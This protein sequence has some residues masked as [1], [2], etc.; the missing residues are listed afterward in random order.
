[1]VRL[2]RKH[3]AALC[4]MA[5]VGAL[6]M[7]L[8]FA[9]NWTPGIM[10][11]P[12]G[13]AGIG[14]ALSG[15]RIPFQ[16]N[17][18]Q[19]PS[20][21]AFGAR[22]FAGSVFV[23]REGGIVYSL[24]GR[25]EEGIAGKARVFRETLIGGNAREIF[26]EDQ[27]STRVS[28]FF[29]NDPAK[30]I[31]EIRVWDTLA[32]NRVYN[33]I[34]LK[35]I[36]RGGSVEKVFHVAP[37]A[38]PSAIRLSMEGTDRLAINDRGELE[39]QAGG[40]TV[41][42]TAPVAWQEDAEGGKKAVGAAYEVSGNEYGFRL[43]GYDPAKEVIIDPLLAATYLG[44]SIGPMPD[45]FD[46]QPY[47]MDFDSSGNI[48]VVGATGSSN[49][50]AGPGYDNTFNGSADAFVV[51]LS[52]D[53]TR[54]VSMTFLGGSQDDIATAVRVSGNSVYVAGSTKSSGFPAT[55]APGSNP[56]SS[57]WRVFVVKLDLSLSA[58]TLSL[59]TILNGSFN[60]NEA[61]L[62][63]DGSGNVF[64][65]GRTQ[66]PDFP[67]TAGTYD[68]LVSGPDINYELT[69]FF[70]AKFDGSTLSLLA[71]TYLRGPS[72]AP[73]TSEALPSISVDGGGNV[74]LAG[75]TEASD[76][77]TTLGAYNRTGGG[78]QI[79]ASKLNNSLTSLLYSTFVGP[80]SINYRASLSLDAGDNVWIGGY[81]PTVGGGNGF[82]TKLDS[83][84]SSLLASTYVGGSGNDFVTGIVAAPGNTVYVTG[85]TASLDFP[86]TVGAIDNTFHG[87][88]GGYDVFVC[89]YNGDLTSLLASTALVQINAG[90]TRPRTVLA[91]DGSGNIYVAGN[92]DS[93]AF[94]TTPGA[95]QPSIQPGIWCDAFI[96]MLDPTLSADSAA[97]TV[98][99]ILP[100]S[101]STGVPVDNAISVIFSERMKASTIDNVTITV[102]GVPGTV[103]FDGN[104]IAIFRP[105]D[106]LAAGTL[107]TVTV[108]TGVQ[109]YS[110]NG[111]A[112]NFISTFTTAAV[113][114][115]PSHGRGSSGCVM[116]VCTNGTTED[117]L[118]VI[119][120]LLSPLAL[121]AARR[122]IVRRGGRTRRRNRQC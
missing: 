36:A 63:L 117:G 81:A 92:T 7:I 97:P 44:G 65:A 84:L 52:P 88:T 67:I 68:N 72:G 42:F 26:G 61:S 107:Y 49:F 87:G 93:A 103:T 16:E 114:T 113:S 66:S 38:D 95:V 115:G 27:S 14:R 69:D 31:R 37:G 60:D 71:S 45:G 4:A 25:R 108:T 23:T 17:A 51:R 89:R 29:G 33:G 62:A 105:M 22:M 58:S 50:P 28:R 53:M 76:Y 99:S 90:G 109:D 85:Q 19:F 21:V 78:T 79:V 34:D 59:G 55:P 122:V 121:I 54:I 112:A 12:P 70:I 39:V 100:S 91:L 11:A 119:M 3:A 94:N 9:V 32:L 74:V 48:Y 13:P 46:D 96:A 56:G 77:P 120:T 1:M 64:V 104:R 57:S 10:P 30:W 98:S 18:G 15:I 75:L 106:N 5:F 80:S 6:V 35:L 41:R 86:K 111:M 101:G 82:V 2:H 40:E 43:A 24:S 47:A 110:G 118:S 116:M 8:L 83:T 73:G 20:D 102:A